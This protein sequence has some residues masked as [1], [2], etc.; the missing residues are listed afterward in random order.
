LS[1]STAL[2]PLLG[3]ATTN[4]VAPFDVGINA[5][6]RREALHDLV[7]W[8]GLYSGYSRSLQQALTQASMAIAPTW[9]DRAWLRPRRPTAPSRLDPVELAAIRLVAAELARQCEGLDSD[10]Q[11][12]PTLARAESDVLRDRARLSP[13]SDPRAPAVR[14][15]DRQARA[16]ARAIRALEKRGLNPTVP[17]RSEDERDA[18][19]WSP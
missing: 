4:P 10:P 1:K 2:L 13:Y 9:A 14:L 18:G 6:A 19:A 7:V 17:A 16:L 3:I 8:I 15:L 5:A 11:V 12:Y